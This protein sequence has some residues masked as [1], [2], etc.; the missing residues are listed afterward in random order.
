MEEH[1]IEIGVE[2]IFNEDT[3]VT[4]AFAE[5]AKETLVGKKMY[6][7]SN[8]VDHNRIDYGQSSTIARAEKKLDEIRLY[9]A[10]GGFLYSNNVMVEGISEEDRAKIGSVKYDDLWPSLRYAISNHLVLQSI[11]NNEI[12]DIV[13]VGMTIAVN[14]H[15]GKI[16]GFVEGE[17]LC[18]S[19]YEAQCGFREATDEDVKTLAK[20]RTKELAAAL[21]QS[22]YNEERN[23]KTHIELA[24][25]AAQNLTLYRY[26][27]DHPESIKT[28]FDIDNVRLEYSLLSFYNASKY[29]DYVVAELNKKKLVN[30]GTYKFKADLSTVYMISSDINKLLSRCEFAH[31]HIHA[32]GKM[33]LGEIPAMAFLV[34]KENMRFVL[35]AI[36]Y[37]STTEIPEKIAADATIKNPRCKADEEK[38]REELDAHCRNCAAKSM[39]HYGME[40]EDEYP[41]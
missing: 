37:K 18:M 17:M 13:Q 2:E 12:M 9:R 20:E 36:N 32:E 19:H 31:P 14:Q 5:W 15:S 34:G 39:C 41:D 27:M 24:S 28:E 35:E 11:T 6:L 8:I 10:A 40:V 29:P 7:V 16:V 3:E 33:C 25:K 4:H 21:K 23:F 38:T 1:E 22:I 30:W 26:S